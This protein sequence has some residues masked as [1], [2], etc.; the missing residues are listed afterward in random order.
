[1]PD[2]IPDAEHL[3]F[4]NF[5]GFFHQTIQGKSKDTFSEI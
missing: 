2:A 3:R 5:H 4:Y 1:M